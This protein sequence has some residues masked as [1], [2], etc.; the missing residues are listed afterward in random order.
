MSISKSAQIRDYI[1]TVRRI[2]SQRKPIAFNTNR[3]E[4]YIRFYDQKYGKNRNNFK[5]YQ[6]YNRNN[7][8][9]ESFL[10]NSFIIFT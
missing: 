3:F 2:N 4:N 6:T 7:A 8:S 10:N 1:Q 9:L 5:R